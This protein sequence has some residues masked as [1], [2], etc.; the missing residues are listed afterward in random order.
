MSLSQ[1]LYDPAAS[2]GGVLKLTKRECRALV[3]FNRRVAEE[4]PDALL[5]PFMAWVEG[6]GLQPLRKAA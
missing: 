5:Y 6:S 4:I 3:E 1:R 2:S